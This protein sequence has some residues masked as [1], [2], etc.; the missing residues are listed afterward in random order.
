M[1]LFSSFIGSGSGVLGN[2]LGGVGSI[3]TG[4]VLNTSTSSASSGGLATRILTSPAFWMAGAL[5][6]VVLVK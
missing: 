2:L 1:S 6:V 4:G 5:V 3:G